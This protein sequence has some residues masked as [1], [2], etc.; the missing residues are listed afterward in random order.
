MDTQVLDPRT[1]IAVIRMIGYV[2]PLQFFIFIGD[3]DT[4]FTRDDWPVWNTDS[5]QTLI[6]LKLRN[7]AMLAMVFINPFTATAGVYEVT[8]GDCGGKVELLDGNERDL[9]TLQQFRDKVLYATPR[10]RAY[11]VLYYIHAP[12]LLSILKRNPAIKAK[13]A[14]VLNLLRPVIDKALRGEQK[15]EFSPEILS[16]IQALCKAIEAE[17]S[18]GLKK[19]VSTMLCDP[20]ILGETVSLDKL[21]KDEN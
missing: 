18:P 6:K 5:L 9:E 2:I 19:V 4:V 11:I 7:R 10:G 21:L 1:V 15:L 17:A 14:H 8:I 13:A 12:E 3:E 20:G 16:E